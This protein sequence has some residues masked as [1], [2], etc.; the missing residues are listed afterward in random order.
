MEYQHKCYIMETTHRGPFY[1]AR[2]EYSNWD[3]GSQEILAENAPRRLVWKCVLP[4]ESALEH[5]EIFRALA[6]NANEAG[7]ERGEL[8]VRLATLTMSIPSKA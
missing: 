8:E 4:G 3:P 1:F 6:E 2:W 7:M 5:M